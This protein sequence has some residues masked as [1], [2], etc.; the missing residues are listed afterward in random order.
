M[1]TEEQT[2]QDFLTLIQIRN[3]RIAELELQNLAL[4]RN[5]CKGGCNNGNGNTIQSKKEGQEERNQEK[6]NEKG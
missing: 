1:T 4:S 3:Q 6:K 2:N 5:Q